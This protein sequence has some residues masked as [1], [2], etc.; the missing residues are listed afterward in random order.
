MS[1]YP[2]HLTVD[3][4]LKHGFSLELGLS[5]NQITGAKMV[6]QAYSSGM[7]FS[8]DLNCR[9]SFYQFLQ[10]T[11]WFDPYIG[12]GV[13]MTYAA[14]ASAGFYP[15]A[16]GIVGTNFWIGNFGIRLQG[17]AKFG[18]VSNFY[19]NNTNYL[20][21]TASVL[22]RI[23]KNYNSKYNNTKPRHKW[24]RKKPGKYKGGRSK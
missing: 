15:T 13:G 11:R 2:T 6:N 21:Y 24:T 9:Y 7:M 17:T 23:P 22:Y 3:R 1:P 8:A 14:T 12:V 19:Y 4:Y 5:Y 20:Q 16:N 18:I 10:P